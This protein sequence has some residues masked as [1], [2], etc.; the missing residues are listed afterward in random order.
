VQEHIFIDPA[1]V[2]TSLEE[3]LIGGWELRISGDVPPSITFKRGGEVDV[4]ASTGSG[5]LVTISGAWTVNED[6]LTM[7]AKVTEE[8]KTDAFIAPVLSRFTTYTCS[9]KGDVLVLT[10][11]DGEETRW[12]KM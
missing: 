6:K 4:T 12:E 3:G 7:R 9:L 1:R 10:N 2:Q 5:S 11:P 8:Q